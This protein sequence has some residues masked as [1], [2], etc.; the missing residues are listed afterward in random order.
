M[1]MDR[2]S[3]MPRPHF[4]LSEMNRHHYALYVHNCRLV[5]LLRKDFDQ[6]DTF[7][8]AEFHWKLDQVRFSG[9]AFSSLLCRD[10]LF[11]LGVVIVGRLSLG[12]LGFLILDKS[13]QEG[14]QNLKSGWK[15][16]PESQKGKGP[17]VPAEMPQG[18]RTCA[19]VHPYLFHLLFVALLGRCLS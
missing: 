19:P 8:P 16:H 18:Q 17:H 3:L 14:T 12:L 13:V 10:H 15:L 2:D 9:N 6:A 7:R 5:F 4:C 11:A 1:E